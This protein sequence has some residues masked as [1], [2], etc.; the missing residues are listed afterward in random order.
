MAAKDI[1]SRLKSFCL[2]GC[3]SGI[4]PVSVLSFTLIKCGWL[5][6]LL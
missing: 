1:T 2:C 3:L 4:T 5:R 6:F